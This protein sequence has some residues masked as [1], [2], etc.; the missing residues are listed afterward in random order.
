MG[1]RNNFYQALRE[2]FGG[3]KRDDAAAGSEDKQKVNINPDEGQPPLDNGQLSENYIPDVSKYY[4]RI[5]EETVKEYSDL[6]SDFSVGLGGE[7]NEAASEAEKKDDP[8]EWPEYFNQTDAY[9]PMIPE[10]AEMTIISKNTMVFGDI[11]SLANITIEGKVQGNVDV[12]KDAS[13][14]GVLVGDLA[15]E[16]T[17]MRGSS[18]QGNVV[19][20]KNVLIYDNALLIG[21]LTAQYSIIDG[22]VKGDIDIAS[23]IRL[24][25]NAVVAGDINTGTIAIEEG[26]NVKGFVNTSFFDEHGDVAF[27]DEVE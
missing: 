22:K 15:C 6:D 8:A 14:R 26:A 18:V 17:D 12:L 2:L 24:N 25:S 1:W 13:I 4:D 23:K 11:K 7:Y 20:N 9:K 16:S 19:A 21:D 3:G 5:L 10:P 27:P